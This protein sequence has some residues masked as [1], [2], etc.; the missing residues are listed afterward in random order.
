MLWMWPEK[1][2]KKKLTHSWSSHCD[3]VGLAA[4][5]ER[6]DAGLIPRLAQWVHDLELLR[7]WPRSP[8]WLGFNPWPLAWEL[9]HAVGVA[10]KRQKNKN[11]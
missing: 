10:L 7:L 8:L 3:T 5:W 9:P 11:N 2:K 1:D 6:W 4:S